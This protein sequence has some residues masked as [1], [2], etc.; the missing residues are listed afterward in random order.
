MLKA[1]TAGTVPSVT[2]HAV[3]RIVA[4]DRVTWWS[5]SRSRS[6]PP[7]SASATGGG[8]GGTMMFIR[9]SA[10]R[11]VPHTFINQRPGRYK[12]RLGPS[13]TLQE[14]PR[15]QEGP[16]HVFPPSTTV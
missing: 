12:Q 14:F 16:E 2:H 15:I 5:R 1:M 8:A 3:A 9:T 10:G 4:A 11:P 7:A 6:E 13:P